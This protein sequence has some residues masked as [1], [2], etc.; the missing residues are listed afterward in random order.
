MTD[1]KRIDLDR[2]R[3]LEAGLGVAAA[4]GFG[5]VMG[6]GTVHPADSSTGL[7]PTTVLGKTGQRLPILGCGGAAMAESLAQVVNVPPLAF[8]ARVAMIRRAFDAGIRYFDTARIY[9][10]SESVYG[11]ALADVRDQVFLATK[12]HASEPSE[13]RKSVETS[14]VELA[15]DRID[16]IQIH[17]QRLE[18]DQA[19]AVH[20]ELEKLKAE[21][22]VRFIGLTGHDRFDRMFAKIS[23][24]AF[25]Q[26][27]LAYGYFR[28][29]MGNIL[30]HEDLEWREL[31]LTRAR[32]LG[33]G[34]V[35]MKVMGAW[36]LGHASEKVVPGYD[37]EALG[38][39]PGAAI[40][41]VLQDPRVQV[42]IIGVSTPGDIDANAAT[43]RGDPTFTGSDRTVL[44]DFCTR[45]YDSEFL[46]TIEQF[47][48]ARSS[49]RA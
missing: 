48:A 15:T 20:A 34:I 1:D 19:M 3:F 28:K 4:A 40:R 35:A 33:M 2:R 9:G 31:C 23:T 14:L 46:K 6:A 7:I 22:L 8:E 39:L 30:T 10:D 41:W 38:R 49:E 5:G 12:V 29:G 21:G 16:C 44:A 11:H 36:V 18:L 43:L 32:E 17:S 13:V 37:P 45:A 47:I 25:D 27:L 42:M 26:V 24:G